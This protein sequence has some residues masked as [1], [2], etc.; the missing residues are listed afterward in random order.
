MQTSLLPKVANSAI[1]TDELCSLDAAELQSF[2]DRNSEYFLICHGEPPRPDEAA[3]ELKLKLPDGLTCNKQWFIGFRE[4][5]AGL[6]A[7]E[8]VIKNLF[9]EGVWHIG[10][11]IL[12]ACRHGKGDAQSI[13]AATEHWAVTQGARWLRIGVVADNLRAQRFWNSQG[14][15]KVCERQGVVMGV[16]KNTIATMIKA[17]SGAT[18]PQYLELVDRDRS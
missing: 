14:F 5:G 7:V 2:F 8:H 10:L 13:Y 17:L 1:H 15:S 12:D 3:T 11:L 6:V 4:Q 9:V 18:I 16:K